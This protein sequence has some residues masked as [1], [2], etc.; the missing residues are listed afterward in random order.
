MVTSSHKVSSYWKDL[1]SAAADDDVAVHATELFLHGSLYALRLSTFNVTQQRFLAIR[2]IRITRKRH[3]YEGPG[4]IYAVT[5][6]AE[7]GGNRWKLEPRGEGSRCN[8]SWYV[9]GGI[10]FAAAEAEWLKGGPFDVGI[11]GG[12]LYTS[13][14]Q[15]P[16]AE[17]K[18]LAA[19]I[20]KFSARKLCGPDFTVEWYRKDISGALIT[21]LQPF[22][23]IVSGNVHHT[24]ME[25]AQLGEI[26]CAL[27]MMVNGYSQLPSR[28]GGPQGEGFDGVFC[29]LNRSDPKARELFVCE[30]KFRE[31]SYTV[32]AMMDH[33]LAEDVMK[34]VA[35]QLRHYGGHKE[36]ETVRL[37]RGFMK[38]ERS[39]FK[40]VFR[41]VDDGH[42]QSLAKKAS[43]KAWRA[44]G[45]DW[46]QGFP[47]ALQLLIDNYKGSTSEADMKAALTAALESF[48]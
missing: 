29:S 7:G 24:H 25:R 40:A 32:E 12:K 20:A 47:A 30:A 28:Y 27:T 22:K 33:H 46:E 13:V 3:T 23:T 38:E 44:A 21:E 37:L 4:W 5:C 2:Y 6:R 1:D 18:D 26:A 16:N 45:H 34:R 42:V 14:A 9:G 31:A 39:V 17:A 48:K 41:L 36:R 19:I 8:L 10:D 11:G 15:L 43:H 35:G